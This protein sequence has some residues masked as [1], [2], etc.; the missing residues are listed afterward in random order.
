MSI[1]IQNIYQVTNNMDRS[2]A[3][4]RDTLGFQMKFRDG[5]KWS[6]LRVE[7]QSFSL[8]SPEEAGLPSGSNAVVVF[9]V[10][11]LAD[12]RPVLEAAGAPILQE[13][14][15]GDHGCSLTSRDPDGNV[16]QFFARAASA[17]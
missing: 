15:M 5:D 11:S 1:K 13:R 9:E 17:A 4:Y 2:L 16:I 8:S 10:S 12:V 14:D 7:G 3:F 6:Q